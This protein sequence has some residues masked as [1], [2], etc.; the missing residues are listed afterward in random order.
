MALKRSTQ[1]RKVMT[2]YIT[3]ATAATTAATTAAIAA[4]A[5]RFILPVSGERHLAF[6]GSLQ[7]HP[8]PPPQLPLCLKHLSEL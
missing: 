1:G 7:I 5:P 6:Q 8:P 2:S 3:A 4:A